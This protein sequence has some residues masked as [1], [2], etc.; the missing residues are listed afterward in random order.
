MPN[1]Q[2]AITKLLSDLDAVAAEVN[3]IPRGTLEDNINRMT[4]Q[5]RGMAARKGK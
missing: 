4:T 1:M 5:V 2:P 3:R